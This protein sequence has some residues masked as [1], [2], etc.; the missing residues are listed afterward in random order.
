MCLLLPGV[1]HDKDSKVSGADVVG[2]ND[3][4]IVG[5]GVLGR[6]VAE[7]WQKV[8]LSTVNILMY[9]SITYMENHAPKLVYQANGYTVEINLDP[10]LLQCQKNYQS[11][12]FRHSVKI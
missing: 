12:C 2:Q 4:L 11:I 10:E 5:P 3:L 7:K 8:F 6:I 1:S 9:L